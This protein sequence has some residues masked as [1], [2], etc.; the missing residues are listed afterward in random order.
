MQQSLMETDEPRWERRSDRGGGK[1]APKGGSERFPSHSLCSDG[2]AAPSVHKPI[3]ATDGTCLGPRPRL[4]QERAGVKP[5]QLEARGGQSCG[6]ERR[7]EVVHGS[8]RGKAVLECHRLCPHSIAGISGSSRHRYRKIPCALYWTKAG[9]Q[10]PALTWERSWMCS[11]HR[12]TRRG[13][14]GTTQ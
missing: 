8:R 3:P 10:V 9:Q 12:R 13:D 7:A 5:A 6:N 4:F 1:G 11:C 2:N 14:R